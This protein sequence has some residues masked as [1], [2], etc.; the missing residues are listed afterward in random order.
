MDVGAAQMA[1]SIEDT[2]QL[3][4]TPFLEVHLLRKLDMLQPPVIMND[5]LHN[6]AGFHHEPRVF[7]HSSDNTG[8]CHSIPDWAVLSNDASHYNYEL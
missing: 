5:E 8:V 3:P 7:Q 4:H 6:T 2:Q 1:H